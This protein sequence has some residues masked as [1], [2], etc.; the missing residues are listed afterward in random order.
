M[1]VESLENRGRRLEVASSFKGRE[2]GEKIKEKK[3]RKYER[4][5]SQKQKNKK[6]KEKIH[7]KMFRC[8]KRAKLT[9]PRK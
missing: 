7:I 9:K 1:G 8:R 4:E 3:K 5:K 2:V 6:K